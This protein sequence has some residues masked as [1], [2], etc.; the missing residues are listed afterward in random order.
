M[1]RN[2]RGAGA[3]GSS[4]AAGRVLLLGIGRLHYEARSVEAADWLGIR[5]SLEHFFG[6]AA[7]LLGSRYAARLEQEDGEV[8]VFRLSADV[9]DSAEQQASCQEAI[10]ALALDLGLETPPLLL[11]GDAEAQEALM[12]LVRRRLLVPWHR[13][14]RLVAEP[15]SGHTCP[16]CLVRRSAALRGRQQLCSVCAARRRRGRFLL[17]RG[18]ELLPRSGPWVAEES[19]FF[20]PEAAA[21][22]RL[23]P[24]TWPGETGETS[25][26]TFR[27]FVATADP[28]DLAASPGLARDPA[29]LL[30]YLPAPLLAAALRRGVARAFGKEETCGGAGPAVACGRADCPVCTVFGF[31]REQQAGGLTGLAAVGD[32]RLLLFPLPTPQG[33][34]WISSPAA[35]RQ[36][37]GLQGF[38]FP[39]P[40]IGQLLTRASGPQLP[41][42]GLEPC[43]GGDSL[44]AI[45]AALAAAGLPATVRR[46]FGL[47]PGRELARL[48]ANASRLPARTYLTWELI[49]RDPR[50]FLVEG[51]A[52]GAVRELRDVE[53]V[54]ARAHPF[55][56]EL[57]LGSGTGRLEGHSAAESRPPRRRDRPRLAAF[58]LA[59][60]AT[61][62]ETL[63]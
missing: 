4:P 34:F 53:A 11:W 60:T 37:K 33:P 63:S 2:T 1:T 42:C 13:P 16:V 45:E 46:S 38:D 54:V 40:A 8:A 19:P 57:G 39:R 26:Q 47:V 43:L 10:D 61:S 36:L 5:E 23:A 31:L 17:G 22:P 32:A 6:A 3:A 21:V 30:P 9:D 20:P 62:P 18:D 49:C 58:E 59:L 48:T 7:E 14:W 35:L 25:F 50:H 29:T 28:A 27:Y 55:L 52:I 15:G 44:K 12:A 41:A 56:A 51:L 24:K